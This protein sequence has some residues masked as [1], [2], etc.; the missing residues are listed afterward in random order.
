MSE[1]RDKW[2]GPDPERPGEDWAIKFDPLV[3]LWTARRWDRRHNANCISAEKLVGQFLEMRTEDGFYRFPRAQLKING[4]QVN[5][6][7]GH[8]ANV[9]IIRLVSP[10]HDRYHNAWIPG[11]TNLDLTTGT[12]VAWNALERPQEWRVWQ[13]EVSGRFHAIRVREEVSRGT[14]RARR[15]SG[16][17]VIIE[18][19]GKVLVFKL[20]EAK[21]GH[22]VYKSDV[23]TDVEWLRMMP[24][25]QRVA[26]PF[27]KSRAAAKGVG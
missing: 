5:H 22:E 15:L 10:Y 19:V 23:V 3:K 1:V 27:I 12:G 25:T 14:V 8:A 2:R 24:A 4:S 21:I 17:N 16:N 7:S 26:L 9:E 11:S 6:T 20:S 18:A 13:D